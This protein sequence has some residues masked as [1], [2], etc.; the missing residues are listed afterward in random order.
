M[1]AVLCMMFSSISGLYLLNTDS[2]QPHNLSPQIVTTKYCQALPA[3][4][5]GAKS[6]QLRKTARSKHQRTHVPSPHAVPGSGQ[7][8]NGVS[9]ATFLT[10]MP[11]TF[12]TNSIYHPFFMARR[13]SVLLSV[14][15]EICWVWNRQW[16]S[17]PILL[18]SH[19][20]GFKLESKTD[21]I[22][23]KAA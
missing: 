21:G 6:S 13:A 20:N 11:F 2:T 23:L 1:E 9:T 4:P 16:I 3:V 7:L 17:F 18:L 10:P 12:R 8:F 14:E 5:W 15:R 22:I 19:P